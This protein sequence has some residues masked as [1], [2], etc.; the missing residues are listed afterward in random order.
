MSNPYNTAT[1]RMSVL[2]PTLRFKGELSAEEDL[3]VEGSVEGTI[4]H[5]SASRS[6]RRARSRPTSAPHSSS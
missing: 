1:E 3:L 2:G 4:R 5:L 6:G